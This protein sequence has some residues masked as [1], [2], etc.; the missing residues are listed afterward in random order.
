MKMLPRKKGGLAPRIC[1]K[2]SSNQH[3][4]DVVLARLYVAEQRE[5]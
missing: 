1:A 3:F 2:F 5:Q 4:G